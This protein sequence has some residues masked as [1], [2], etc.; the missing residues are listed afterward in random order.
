MNTFMALPYCQTAFFLTLTEQLDLHMTC[1]AFP[2]PALQDGGRS[3]D[4]E[5]NQ[6]IMMRYVKF[7]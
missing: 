3:Q 1:K 7:S 5:L 4:N 6:I 2:V